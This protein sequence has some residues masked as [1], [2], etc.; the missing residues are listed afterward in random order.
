MEEEAALG[1]ACEVAGLVVDAEGG[2][3]SISRAAFDR[4]G[5]YS[6]GKPTFEV[7]ARILVEIWGI[8][9]RRLLKKAQARI[10]MQ[11]AVR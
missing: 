9:G 8:W 7:P 6:P 3:M 5:P 2:P 1:A 11:V 4:E 10:D